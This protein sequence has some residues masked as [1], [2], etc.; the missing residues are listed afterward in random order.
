VAS[1]IMIGLPSPKRFEQFPECTHD[2]DRAEGTVASA[3][4]AT[5][6][7][8]PTL[9][10]SSLREHR[11]SKAKRPLSVRERQEI[12]ELPCRR[13][14][15]EEPAAPL[16]DRARHRS[17]RDHS[18]KSV[19]FPRGRGRASHAGRT[20]PSRQG[21][22]DGARPLARRPDLEPRPHPHSGSDTPATGRPSSR[23]GMVDRTQPLARH[24]PGGFPHH[25][26]PR[27]GGFGALIRFPHRGLGVKPL[28]TVPPSPPRTA[29][30][31]PDPPRCPRTCARLPWP[32]R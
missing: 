22:V 11:E 7:G 1:S 9:L 12:Q 13:R 18:G 32:R 4:S 17:G 25:H 21:V 26:Q 30:S 23:Q 2:M 8:N 29:R 28:P 31:S 6:T 5:I 14:V 15:E 16:P 24:S 3:I 27:P 10:H 19:L 20:S